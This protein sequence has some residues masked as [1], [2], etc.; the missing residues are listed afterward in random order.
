MRL[1]TSIRS[2]TLDSVTTCGWLKN[3][4]CGQYLRISSGLC[5]PTAAE[6]FQ[7]RSSYVLKKNKWKWKWDEDEDVLM[8]LNQVEKPKQRSHSNNKQAPDQATNSK[9][10]LLRSLVFQ[11]GL[12]YLLVLIG[13][14]CKFVNLRHFV[15]RHGIKVSSA[16]ELPRVYSPLSV[17]CNC[18]RARPFGC[19]GV[20][21]FCTQK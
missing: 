17:C 15:F 6:I 5:W 16:V 8:N 19:A 4:G 18:S 7:S 11:C 9:L 20:W 2:S 12:N 14:I 3:K 13:L 10:Q 1:V 21:Q